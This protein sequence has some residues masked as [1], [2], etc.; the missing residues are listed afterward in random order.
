M[1]SV[2][3]LSNWLHLEGKKRKEKK[4]KFKQRTAVEI[5]LNPFLANLPT[6]LFNCEFLAITCLLEVLPKLRAH[7]MGHRALY[8]AQA[9]LTSLGV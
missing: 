1:C 6:Y 7:A 4:E 5:V 3:L 9:S 2:S 8:S